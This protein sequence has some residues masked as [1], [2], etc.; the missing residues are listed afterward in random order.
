MPTH[1]L[2]GVTAA[3]L[4]VALEPQ[5]ALESCSECSPQKDGGRGGKWATRCRERPGPG[6]TALQQTLRRPWRGRQSAQL[7]TTRKSH[8]QCCPR[9]ALKDLG[10]AS[11]S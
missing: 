10:G 5:L 3:L 11:E 4:C 9:A 8:G 1:A 7:Q 6:S 2:D